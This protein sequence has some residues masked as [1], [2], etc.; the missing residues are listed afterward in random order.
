MFGKI[1]PEDYTKMAGI[2]ARNYTM[3]TRAPGPADSGDAK[4]TPVVLAYVGRDLHYML[5]PGWYFRYAPSL[6]THDLPSTRPP[7][8]SQR[9][10]GLHRHFV[11]RLLPGYDTI[12]LKGL[13]GDA[14]G[15]LLKRH[16]KKRKYCA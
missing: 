11:G 14:Y 2:A 3:G 15:T 10:G 9:Y 7:Q 8:P 1:H 6:S 12:L 16:K 4:E 5:V 13:S